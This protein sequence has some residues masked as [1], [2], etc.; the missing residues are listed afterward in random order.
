MTQSSG[1]SCEIVGEWTFVT[2]ELLKNFK[3]TAIVAVSSLELSVLG[4]S[5]LPQTFSAVL[6]VD[7]FELL[8]GKNLI[9]FAELVEHLRVMNFVVLL[10]KWMRNYGQLSVG[11]G[12]FLMGGGLGIQ[13]QYLVIIHF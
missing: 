6:I 7:L 3:A 1:H 4:V 2:E 13:L 12:Y 5:N 8:A 9:R 11:V 10:S